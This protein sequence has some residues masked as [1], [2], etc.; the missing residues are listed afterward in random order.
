MQVV[1]IIDSD[2]RLA[3]TP[4]LAVLMS[5]AQRSDQSVCS[6]LEGQGSSGHVMGLLRYTEA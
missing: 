2:S 3:L 5:T 6:T 1:D 4:L